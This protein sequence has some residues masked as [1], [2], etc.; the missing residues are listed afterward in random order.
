MHLVDK[1]QGPLPGFAPCPRRLED[2][3]EISD[4]RED[5]G[6][7]L[8][9]ERGG[10]GE[11]PRGRRLAGAWRPPE[12]Q[13]AERARL[14]HAGERTVRP[15]QMILADHLGEFRRTQPVGEGAWRDVI[16]TGGLEQVRVALG[17]RAHPA[18][19]FLSPACG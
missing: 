17:P 9:M 10:V 19:S 2:L 8:E 3:L 11:Q 1:E 6:D 14:Q 5:R 18:L 13:R 4:T 15:E 12:D 7:L 16:E